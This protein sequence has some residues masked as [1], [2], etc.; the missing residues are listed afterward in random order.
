MDFRKKIAKSF[1]IVLIISILASSLAS[2]SGSGAGELSSEIGGETQTNKNTAS[3]LTTEQ[4][5]EKF[6]EIIRIIQNSQT[7]AEAERYFYG[8]DES[9]IPSE[10]DYIKSFRDYNNT[11]LNLV[12]ETDDSF[13]IVRM[14]YT[15][16]KENGNTNRSSMQSKYFVTLVD[17][18]W[19][20]DFTIGNDS[21]IL[22][23]VNEKYES[24]FSGE[25]L[26][27]LNFTQVKSVYHFFI[28]SNE[29]SCFNGIAEAILLCFYQDNDGNLYA[30]VRLNNGKAATRETFKE[31]S[32]KLTDDELGTIVDTT[33]QL[34]ETVSPGTAKNITVKIPNYEVFTGTQAWNGVSWSFHSN[35]SS[36]NSGSGNNNTNQRTVCPICNGAGVVQQVIGMDANGIPQ[37]GMVGCGSCGGSGYIN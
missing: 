15:V 35:S 31:I 6:E 25:G 12:A 13:Y 4:K 7:V 28:T 9:E 30:V 16:F 21:E 29:K 11:M 3:I 32:L 37:Y 1:I 2:C 8:L 5:K 10:I 23:L 36:D 26:T 17:N 27:F 19:K 33:I 14:D 18:E 20:L 34:N 24:Q 22:K